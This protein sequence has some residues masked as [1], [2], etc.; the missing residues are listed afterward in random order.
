MNPQAFTFRIGE[1]TMT[2]LLD[3]ARIIGREGILKRYPDATEADYE[4]AF[5]EIGMSMDEAEF[6]LNVLLVETDNEKILIDGGE[7]GRPHGGLLLESLRQ[8]QID[9]NEITLVVITHTH[10]DHVL[11]LINHDTEELNFPNTRYVIA[12]AEL[13]FWLERIKSSLPAQQVIVDKLQAKGLQ[14]IAVDEQILGGVTAIPLVGHTPGH[15]GV[16]FE[17][18]G[19]Q[20]WNLSDVLHSPIQFAHPEWSAN[21][22]VDTTQSVPTRQHILEQASDKNVLTMFYHLH[23]PGIG[24]VVRHENKFV[25]QAGL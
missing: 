24:R 17:S 6:S 4:Q 18:N 5:A 8:H 12:E 13:H 25:W 20:F 23:F 10:G 3:G 21:F 11:G 19:E 16:R 15:I 2:A 9:P 14:L 1:M 7:G 22:D